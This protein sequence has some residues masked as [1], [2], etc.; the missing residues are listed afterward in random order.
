LDLLARGV[1]DVQSIDR[2]WMID[3]H[4]GPQGIAVRPYRATRIR[5]R[6]RALNPGMLLLA[7]FERSVTSIP[8]AVL[9][10]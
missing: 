10:W 8:D 4:D 1:S 3:P 2:T 9:C 6:K 5:S 7:S